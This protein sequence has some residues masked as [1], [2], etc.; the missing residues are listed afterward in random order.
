M[1][2]SSF[3]ESGLAHAGELVHLHNTFEIFDEVKESNVRMS[4]GWEYQD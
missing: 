2:C 4:A 1:R 3:V